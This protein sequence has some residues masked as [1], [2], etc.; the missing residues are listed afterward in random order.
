MVCDSRVPVVHELLDGKQLLT[1]L[2]HSHYQCHQGCC[3]TRREHNPLLPSTAADRSPHTDTTPV[4]YSG[5][6]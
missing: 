2:T 4:D 5:G 6:S 3:P 1:S